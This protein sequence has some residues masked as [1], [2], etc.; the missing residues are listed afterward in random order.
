MAFA[1]IR[2]SS[3]QTMDPQPNLT[4][5]SMLLVGTDLCPWR[6]F[7]LSPNAITGIR[8]DLAMP[9][10][11]GVHNDMVNQWAISCII[12]V[13]NTGPQS[14]SLYSETVKCDLIE[15]AVQAKQAAEN[16]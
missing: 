9:C 14:K 16:T 4:E 10:S 11:L 6:S 1:K 15:I 3:E 13:Q 12:L 2:E 5:I 7:F 8:S